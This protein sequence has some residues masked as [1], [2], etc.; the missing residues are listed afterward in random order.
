MAEVLDEV[1]MLAMKEVSQSHLWLLSPEPALFIELILIYIFQHSAIV[2]QAV[3][4]T[5]ANLLRMATKRTA[6]DAATM[7]VV[8]DVELV[9]SEPST[10]TVLLLEGKGI[11]HLEKIFV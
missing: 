4:T 8:E 2:P 1:D 3:P 9:E 7:K 5:E 10:D 11:L 6:P